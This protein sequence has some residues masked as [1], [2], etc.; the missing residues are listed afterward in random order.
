MRCGSQIPTR[1]VLLCLTA[2]DASILAQLH[3]P[4]SFGRAPG[5]ICAPSLPTSARRSRLG[6]HTA[7]LLAKPRR[8]GSR[9]GRGAHECALALRIVVCAGRHVITAR[10]GRPILAVQRQPLHVQVWLWRRWRLR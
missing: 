6:L 9:L 1:R 4:L 10:R 2:A 3:A 7:E 5:W 8:A